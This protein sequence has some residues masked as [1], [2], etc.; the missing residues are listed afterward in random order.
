[1]DNLDGSSNQLF[2]QGEL[3]WQ[4]DPDGALEI[5]KQILNQ[6]KIS[7]VAARSAMFLAVMYDNHF[8]QADS[9]IYYYDWLQNH[10]P[11][12]EQAQA[13]INRYEELQQMISLINQVDTMEVQDSS[14]EIFVE[15][16]EI[17]EVDNQVDTINIIATGTE[18]IAKPEELVGVNN[19]ETVE[20]TT[21][22]N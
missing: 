8:A 3:G 2:R 1:M 20:D 7:D 22:E 15:P 4:S 5:F 14:S 12:S 19:K 6:D 16:M 13:T 11:E 9:A 10:K 18:M 17:L 21:I